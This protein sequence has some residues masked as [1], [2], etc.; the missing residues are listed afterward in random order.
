MQQEELTV[1]AARRKKVRKA[2]TASMPVASRAAS[3]AFAQKAITNE[4]V[5]K[6][7]VYVWWPAVRGSQ[8]DKV[9]N[10]TAR[11]PPILRPMGKKDLGVHTM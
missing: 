6:L 2:S 5:K 7:C 11:P 9:E 3:T 1:A 10:S 4:R 8:L